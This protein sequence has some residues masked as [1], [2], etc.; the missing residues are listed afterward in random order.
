MKKYFTGIVVLVA[1][2]SGTAAYIPGQVNPIE[3][4]TTPIKVDTKLVTVPVMVSDQGGGSAKGLTKENFTVISDGRV[5]DIDFFADVDEPMNVALVIEAT[6]CTYGVLEEIKR[7]AKQF[8]DKLLI[9]D[10]AIVVSYD[11]RVYVRAELTDDKSVLKR[12]IDDVRTKMI[13]FRGSETPQGSDRPLFA[14][15]LK[16]VAVEKF[17]TVL[18][19]KAI[20][21]L[22]N[23]CFMQSRPSEV[24]DLLATFANSDTAVYSVYHRLLRPVLD[25]LL[26]Y[27]GEEKIA[28]QLRKKKVLT[29]ENLLLIP[30]VNDFAVISTATGGKIFTADHTDLNVAFEQIAVELR[31]QYVIGF[32]V[33]GDTDASSRDISVTVNRPGLTVRTKQNIKLDQP[34][35]VEK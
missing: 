33:D 35:P 1:L 6:G 10:R 20:I 32:H 26:V 14:D 24:T 22:N 12:S 31:T 18:G 3:E 21:L 15:A 16:K 28:K 4:D 2:L 30:R 5:Q 7:H 27:S 19:R 25:D 13:T 9:G 17:S 29:L 23:D 8:V 34:A 11:D